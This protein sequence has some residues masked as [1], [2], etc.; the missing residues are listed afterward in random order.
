MIKAR[1]SFYSFS[2]RKN[3]LLNSDSEKI[4]QKDNYREYKI[5]VGQIALS[6]S[7]W[8]IYLKNYLTFAIVPLFASL[9]RMCIVNK[10]MCA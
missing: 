1:A 4:H 9:L 3:L 2:L 6:S 8:E 7:K 5:V 10:F